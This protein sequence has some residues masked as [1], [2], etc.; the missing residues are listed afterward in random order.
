MTTFTPSAITVT[1]LREIVTADVALT[2]NPDNQITTL[3]SEISI[4]W[5]KELPVTSNS[6]T[7]DP[8]T[9]QSIARQRH[10]CFGDVAENHQASIRR[11]GYEHVTASRREIPWIRRCDSEKQARRTV[12]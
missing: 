10:G 12:L 2:D 9:D 6:V 4:E 7:E 1:V 3:A 8:P 11:L 5:V